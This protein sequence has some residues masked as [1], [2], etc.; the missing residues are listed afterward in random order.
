[1]ESVHRRQGM[2]TQ[3]G[4]QDDLCSAAVGDAPPAA[5]AAPPESE[6]LLLMQCNQCVWLCP[7]GAPALRLSLAV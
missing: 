3:E 6:R 1:M 2:G 4:L 5:T 7:G